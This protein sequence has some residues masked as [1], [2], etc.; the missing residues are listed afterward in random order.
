MQVQV[1]RYQM[2]HCY[3]CSRSKTNMKKWYF[4]YFI[5]DYF[6]SLFYEQAVVF[7]TISNNINKEWED[8][9]SGYQ[10]W[11]N[12]QTGGLNQRPFAKMR[13]TD[14]LS[15]NDQSNCRSYHRKITNIRNATF[16]LMINCEG[17]Q[18]ISIH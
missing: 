3:L 9:I 14:L 7:W 18:S 6:L 13:T 10:K 15:C 12:T 8:I 16:I 11:K 2:F 5:A 1:V 4:E 17:L